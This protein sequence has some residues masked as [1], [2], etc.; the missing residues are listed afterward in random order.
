MMPN[1]SFLRGIFLKDIKTKSFVSELFIFKID[2]T[3][4]MFYFVFFV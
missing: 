3:W 1:D 2:Q 4:K